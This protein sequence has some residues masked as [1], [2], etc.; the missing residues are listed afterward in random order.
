MNLVVNCPKSVGVIQVISPFQYS[1]TPDFGVEPDRT[2]QT[3]PS[4]LHSQPGGMGS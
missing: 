2:V 1:S 4:F 3:S